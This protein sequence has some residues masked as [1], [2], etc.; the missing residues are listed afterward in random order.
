MGHIKECRK[1]EEECPEVGQHKGFMVQCSSSDDHTN[2][3]VE[4]SP[5]QPLYNPY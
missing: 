2:I 4:L 3:N 5:A 1:H